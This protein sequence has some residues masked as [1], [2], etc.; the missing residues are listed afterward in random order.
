MGLS[1]QFSQRAGAVLK[2][3]HTAKLWGWAVGHTG[4]QRVSHAMETSV[5]ITEMP[6]KLFSKFHLRTD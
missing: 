4:K 3:E 1:S 6:T 5:E 2:P